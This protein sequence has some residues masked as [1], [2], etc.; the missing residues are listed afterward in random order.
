MSKE[1]INAFLGAGTVYEGKLSFQ[2]A[3][4]VDGVFSGEILSEGALIA[5]KDSVISATLH[6]GELV[7]SGT[8]TGDVHAKRRVVVHRGG[9]LTGTVN[10]PALVVEEGAVLEG[11][12]HMRDTTVVKGARKSEAIEVLQDGMLEILN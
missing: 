2:G 9:V 11:A 12:I 6:V 4:R 8:F 5:G 7:L 3:V 10:S 1:E